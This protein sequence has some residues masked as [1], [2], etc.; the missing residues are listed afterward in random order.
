MHS[1]FL[2]SAVVGVGALTLL[3]WL[4]VLLFQLRG[5]AGP[6]HGQLEEP[7]HIAGT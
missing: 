7:G 4:A 3:L 2:T 5:G 1:W 6:A